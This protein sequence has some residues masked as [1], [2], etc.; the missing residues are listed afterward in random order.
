MKKKLTIAAVG[1]LAP[2]RKLTDC[3]SQV[4]EVFEVLR[5]ADLSIANL[6]L[7][8]TTSEFEADKAITLKAHPCIAPSL[9]DGGVN[10]VNI[11][12][13]HA[14]DFGVEG[15]FESIEV[16]E[17]SGVAVVGGGKDL[18][19]A[20]KPAIIEIDGLRVAILG[21]CSALPTGYAAG[22]T[23]P[24]IAPIRAH[25]RFFIDNITLDE[26]PGMSP[27]VETTVNLND[28]EFAC[29]QISSAKADADL[30]IVNM[31]WGIPNG[32]CAS[33]QGPLADY[34]Q[35]LA[36]SLIDAGADIILGHHPHVIH[37][38][39]KYKDGL[40]AYSLGNF[41]FHSMGDDKK[42]ELTVVIY[43]PYKVDSLLTG[44]AREAIIIELD[45]D[46]KKMTEVRFLPIHMNAKG[47][48]EFLDEEDSKRVLKRLEQHSLEFG[49]KIPTEKG[50][51]KIQL[52]N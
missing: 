32:W 1:D 8:L 19:A 22:P 21:F 36:H 39:E 44:E 14:V 18:E 26:Q 20:A 47:D 34:Q 24:G 10:V 48:P 5:Q 49:L 16:V 33:F 3:A 6:E 2:L 23:R 38:I 13:N 43:P 11:A 12:N 42:T 41:L 51:G 30:V 17:A 28:Q 52:N 37:G 40:I 46:E 35:P 31:H 7:P 4:N 25:A 9:L 27:W 29:K 50:I 15:L 45:I